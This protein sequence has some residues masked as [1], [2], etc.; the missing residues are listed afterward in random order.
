[1]PKVKTVY[2]Y[3]I[4]SKVNEI[5][6]E[7]IESINNQLYCNLC[8]CAVACNKRFVVDSHRN[9]SKHQKVFGSISENL[10]PQTSQTFLRGSD[11]DFVEKVTGTSKLR[12]MLLLLIIWKCFRIFY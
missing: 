2:A 1:M 7:F 10:I 5:P 12:Y 3:K 11:I 4:Q 9:T 8:K 6:D